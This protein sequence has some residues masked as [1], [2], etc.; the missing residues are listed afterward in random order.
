MTRTIT[1]S[2]TCRCKTYN[3]IQ[4]TNNAIGTQG[5]IDNRL[6]QSIEADGSLKVAAI[7][8]ALHSIESH[9]DTDDYVRMRRAESDKLA[10]MAD[11]ATNFYAEVEL[12]DEE[13]VALDSGAMRLT[14]S[15]TITWEVVEPNKVRAHIGFPLETAHRHYYDQAPVHVNE[16][17]PDF[18]N[19]LV[20]TVTTPFVEGSLR[21]YVNG[22]R[23]SAE[24]QIYIAGHLITDPWTQ[25]TYT[26]DAANG[27]FTLSVALSEEDV[28]RIDYDI[29]FF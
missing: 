19:Y 23:L 29:S 13:I 17:S 27:A 15:S 9:T 5:S 22:M 4:Q 11:G 16:V 2:T 14:P 6:N 20:N 10:L 28:I 8:E 24:S 18:R 25:M 3:V 7:D 1:T 12:D 21:V 26:E